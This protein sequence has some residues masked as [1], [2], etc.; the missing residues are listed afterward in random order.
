MLTQWKFNPTPAW[1]QVLIT[2]CCTVLLIG[3]GDTTTEDPTTTPLSRVALSMPDSMTGGKNIS[4]SAAPV[5]GTNISK[6]LAAAK[7]IATTAAQGTSQPCAFNGAGSDDPFENGYHMTRF[8]VGAIASWTCVADLFINIAEFVPNDGLIKE[9]DNNTNAGSYDPKD[10]THYSV[11]DEGGG[12]IA[13]RLYYGFDRAMPPVAA[14]IPQFFAAWIEGEGDNIDGRLVFDVVTIAGVERNSDDPAAMRLDFNYTETQKLATMYIKFDGGNEWANGLRIEVTEDLGVNPLT[15]VY[16]A[17]GLLDMKRQFVDTPGVPELPAFQMYTTANKLG[18]G[19]AIADFVDVALPLELN[20]GT[21]N[22]LGNYIFT[23]VDKYFFQEDES[24][25]WVDKAITT[26]EY[27]G[28][29]TTPATGGT[30]LPFDPSLDLIILALALDPDY[31][32]GTA[33][34][35][36]GDDCNDLL[37]AIFQDGFSDQ[38]PN[39]GTDPM[40]WRSTV[41]ETPSYL[42]SVYPNGM[43]WDGAFDPVF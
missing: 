26:S 11:T 4:G 9:T 41:V 30:L 31:F 18:E 1:R 22:H 23:K 25:D 15:Q 8:L 5:A 40:D 36:V 37:N 2:A 33:C 13:V 12:K 39:Q 19:A 10:P 38:E 35:A 20:A 3:C 42:G 14:D 29:R 24:W 28:V 32:T 7:V 27:R 43:N 6:S 16:L 34:N 17:R 21:G